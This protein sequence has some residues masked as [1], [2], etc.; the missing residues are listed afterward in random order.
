L[1]INKENNL[2][3]RV[4][5]T[6]LAQTELDGIFAYLVENNYG[7]TIKFFDDLGK[8]F[9]LLS[10]NPKMGTLHQKYIVGMRSFPYKRYVIFYFPTENGIEIYRVIHD[11]RDIDDL[12]ESQFEG[13]KP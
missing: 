1:L 6:P 13:L 12:F 3:C 4:E 11:A 10:E 8:V 7:S 2:Y 9:R 5:I